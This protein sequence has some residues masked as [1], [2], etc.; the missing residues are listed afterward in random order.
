MERAARRCRSGEID[1]LLSILKSG[2]DQRRVKVRRI[3]SAIRAK[4][5]ENDLKVSIAMDRLIREIRG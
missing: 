2:G 1:R 4:A 5:Y 3:R